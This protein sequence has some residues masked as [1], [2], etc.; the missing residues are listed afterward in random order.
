MNRTLILL[1]IY[2]MLF[3]TATAQVEVKAKLVDEI[4]ET[5][6]EELTTRIQNLYAEMANHP[7]S[8]TTIVISGSDLHKRLQYERLTWGFIKSSKLDPSLVTEIRGDSKGKIRI[9][10]WF[11][12]K[13][14][15]AP[16]IEPLKWDFTLPSQAKSVLLYSD[17]ENSLCES[18]HQEMILSEFLKANTGFSGQ[19]IIYSNT[20]KRFI[21]TRKEI[22]RN[23]TASDLGRIRFVRERERTNL[24][25]DLDVEWWLVPT[26]KLL[27]NP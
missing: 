1:Y 16:Q 18:G 22:I 13:G 14:A 25:L 21:Q 6:C 19:I 26:K 15:T 5:F 9:Q 2:L 17:P 4:G 24:A 3:S 10:F 8:R 23:F 12:P 27:S 11:V 7:G 20:M